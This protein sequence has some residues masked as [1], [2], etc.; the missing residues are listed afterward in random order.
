[1][2]QAAPIYME[3]GRLTDAAR[4]VKK[5]IDLC[6]EQREIRLYREMEHHA[7]IFLGRIYSLN[8][9]DE[10]AEE[11]LREAEKREAELLGSPGL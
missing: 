5:A 3:L 4:Q 6:G 10:K 9:E 8:Q 11:A 2:D 7:Y 1:M